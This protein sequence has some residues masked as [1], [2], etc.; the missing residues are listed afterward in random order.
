MSIPT[1]TI[2]KEFKKLKK[3]LQDARM[4]SLFL[5]HNLPENPSLVKVDLRIYNAYWELEDAVSVWTQGDIYG[6]AEIKEIKDV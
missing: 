5:K 6:I 1:E 3:L 4:V 2:S